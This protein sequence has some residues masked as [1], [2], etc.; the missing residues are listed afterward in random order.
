MPALPRRAYPLVAVAMGIAWALLVRAAVDDVALTA[1]LEGVV[2]GLSASGLYSGVVET[3]RARRARSR[4]MKT[5]GWCHNGYHNLPGGGSHPPRAPRPPRRR[6]SSSTAT[7]RSS[8]RS[9]PPASRGASSASPTPRR[10]PAKRDML[11]DAVDAGARSPSPTASPTTAAAGPTPA[12]DRAIR[13][14]I[15]AF[16]ARHPQRPA[17]HLRRPAPRPQPR[18]RRSSARPRAAASMAGCPW[19]TPRPS[20]R[21]SRAAF[22][23]AYPGAHVPRPAVRAR[24]P[25]LRRHRRR[26]SSREQVAEARTPRRKVALDLRPRDRDRR[27]AARAESP[28]RATR[29]IRR[30]STPR[31]CRPSSTPTCAARV[32]I[33]D[34]GTPGELRG[35]GPTSS[36]GR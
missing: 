12:R 1:A 27:R 2:V 34:H 25:D 10:P 30:R 15:D 21:P 5:Y 35:L 13:T 23:A 20:A 31:L 29:A 9:P 8:A 3:R 22:D 6:S 14:L 4:R 26:R 11:A 32:A 24:D 7:P 17:L 18:L 16:R 19:S 33:L 36:R 28:A